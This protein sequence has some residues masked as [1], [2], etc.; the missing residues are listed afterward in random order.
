MVDEP[1]SGLLSPDSTTNRRT[2]SWVIVALDSNAEPIVVSGGEAMSEPSG[3]GLRLDVRA[4]WSPGGERFFYLRLN[5]GEIQLWEADNQGRHSRQVTHSPGD[6]IDVVSSSD[7]NRLL[8][9]VAPA[10]SELDRAEQTEYEH[11][12]LYGDALLSEAPVVNNFPSLGGR[13]SLRQTATGQLHPAGWSGAVDR[14]IDISKRPFRLLR[15]DA[16]GSDMPDRRESDTP[17]VSVVAI[18]PNAVRGDIYRGFYR[19]MA[20]SND[21]HTATTPCMAAECVANHLEVLGWSEDATEVEFLSDS[22]S[23]GA[24]LRLPG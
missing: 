19:V 11:G 4:V 8:V 7:R 23:R 22:G 24:P 6:L 20:E 5:A 12:V 16:K 15:L 1:S 18:G 21:A 17:G 9:R 2:L 14:V 3:L 13:R 10:R